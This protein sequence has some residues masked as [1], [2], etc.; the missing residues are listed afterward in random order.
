MRPLENI[1]L[2]LILFSSLN[3]I[4][5]KNKKI[6]FYLPLV[7]IISGISSII[8]EGYRVH[9]VPA[10]IFSLVILTH[11]I[12]KTLFPKRKN[13]KLLSIIYAILLIL[14]LFISIAIPLV[15]PVVR[16]HKPT[17]P[18]LVGTKIMSF[19]DTS[20]IEK[21]SNSNEYRNVPVQV[22]YPTSNIKGKKAANWINSSEAMD[23]LSESWNL[24]NILEHFSLVKTHSYL[25]TDVSEKE[26]KYP[27]ILFSGGY[28]MFNGQNVIQMEELA[29][30][31][32]IVFSVGHPYE[33]F[34]CIYP[35]GKITPSSKK[36]SAILSDDTS[37][38]INNAKKSKIN[39]NDAEFDRTIIRNAK[40]S[41]ASAKLWSNDM[42]FTINKITDMNSGKINSIFLD[43]LDIESIGAFGHSFGGAA[44]SQLC[45]QDNRVK[46]FINMDGTPFGDSPDKIIN[47]PF[48]ILTHKKN[49]KPN[50]PYGYSKNQK[51]FMVVYIDG[52]EH[53]NFSD[54]NSLIPFL[55]KITTLLGDVKE[56]RQIEIMNDYII[57]FFNKHLKGT[58]SPS[59]V[60]EGSSSKYP[61]VTI[62]VK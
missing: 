8:F 11:V 10:L 61:E 32:Y 18:H 47:Q 22:W 12:L 2:C 42:S 58:R 43:K 21:L 6:Q 46:A 7:T 51:N 53:M 24:P 16:L 17:G 38:A 33:D 28:G 26:K 1:F 14:T 31:G 30:K 57:G 36:Q 48:M 50:I 23:F 37:K 49:E 20:R 40:F 44:S 25:N 9:I 56:N 29:S 60:I 35:D 59:S 19:V 52:A 4:L 45:I 34:A 27:V 41:N 39:E 15:F 62:D 13:N 5:F 54:L 55:G 3:L